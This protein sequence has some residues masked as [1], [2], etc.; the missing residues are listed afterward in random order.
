MN[1][2][3]LKQIDK[4]LRYR[5]VKRDMSCPFEITILLASGARSAIAVRNSG[6]LACARLCREV[7]GEGIGGHCAKFYGTGC[8]CGIIGIDN[9]SKRARFYRR[10]G[11]RD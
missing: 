4:W 3:A 2:T 5:K 8:P 9:V 10:F 7:I 6:R 1:Q 11:R